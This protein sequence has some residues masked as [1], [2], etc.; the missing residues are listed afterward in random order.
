MAPRPAPIAIEIATMTGGGD[1]SGRST[2]CVPMKYATRPTI[3]PTD[4]SMFRV[5][6]TSVWPTATTAIDG[7]ARADPGERPRP[8]DS[9]RSA[10]R[11]RRDHGD[12]DQDEG[13]ARGAAPAR[14]CAQ[15]HQSRIDAR[16]RRRSSAAPGPSRPP[17]PLLRRL[18]AVE[19]RHLAALAHD[20]D[21]VA[22]GE[23]LR[24]VGADQDD[25]D[26]LP[27]PARR[28][29]WWTSALA[30]TSM[31]RVG[32]SRISTRGSRVQP[33]A[34]DDLLLV[35]A[36]QRGDRHMRPMAARILSRSR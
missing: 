12:D 31:P 11:R 22:H 26:A 5:R 29:I 10:W 32:S 4:R 6:T 35:A 2:A 21:P 30:P 20:Q 3:E 14:T 7:H 27:A 24:Q 16:R 13:R 9:R 8:R 36:R 17:G 33:L 34:Q 1:A 15:Q 19:D 28:S 18:V 25:R 23:D